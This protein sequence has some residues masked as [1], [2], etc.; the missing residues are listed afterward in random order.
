MTLLDNQSLIVLARAMCLGPQGEY[1][2]RFIYTKELMHVFDTDEEKAD[3]P[4]KFDVQIEKFGDPNAQ[5]SAQFRAET[6]AFWRALMVL[7]PEKA[8]LKLLSDLTAQAAS[9]E[10][11]AA[12]LRVPVGVIREFLRVDF[13]KITDPLI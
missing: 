6:K 5:M 12:G 4:A 1:E 2:R 8:R 13:K 10:V 9:Q 11:L 3:T 7:C